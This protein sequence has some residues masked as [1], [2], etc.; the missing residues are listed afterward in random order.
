MVIVTLFIAIILLVLLIIIFYLD[1]T[2]SL[3]SKCW[4]NIKTPE[5]DYVVQ[6]TDKI[7]HELKT[8]IPTNKWSKWAEYDKI[9]ETPIFTKLTTQEIINRIKENEGYLNSGS[10]SWRLFGLILFGQ[11]IESNAAL[12]PFTTNLL[13]KIPYIM[14]AGFSCLEPG[15]STLLHRDYNDKIYRCHI[16]LIIPEG[17]CA[18]EVDNQIRKWIMGEYFIFNDTCYHKAWNNTGSNR[19]I[20]IIDL[21]RTKLKI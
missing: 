13:L 2:V 9:N 11:K 4:I 17:D 20:L 5:L 6:S 14:N 19:Y 15:V 10:S 16:P 7:L 12:C 3:D 8:V 21:D 18:I 1:N